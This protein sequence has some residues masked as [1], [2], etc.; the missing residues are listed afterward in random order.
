M[1]GYQYNSTFIVLDSSEIPNSEEFMLAGQ[2]DQVKMF[3]ELTEATDAFL[4]HV[5]T[6]TNGGEVVSHA[7]V[8]FAGSLIIQFVLRSPK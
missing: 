1:A 8:P 4:E 5:E 3:Q 6:V 7:I 2:S